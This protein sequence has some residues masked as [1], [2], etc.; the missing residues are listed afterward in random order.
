MLLKALLGKQE[1]NIFFHT[2]PWRGILRTVL[3]LF[4]LG[5]LT[6]HF[7]KVTSNPAHAGLARFCRLNLGKTYAIFQ[8][9]WT[10]IMPL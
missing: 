10:D 2:Q 3:Q 6:D 4:L 1:W 7:W 8:M 9:H 5:K